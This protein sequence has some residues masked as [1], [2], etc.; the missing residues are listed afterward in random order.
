MFRA[1][2]A[3]IVGTAAVAMLLVAPAMACT[4]PNWVTPAGDPAADPPE[5]GSDFPIDAGGFEPGSV[6][7]RLDGLD[8]ES[9]GTA[10]AGED[11]RFSAVVQLPAELEPGSH[12]IV[13]TQTA[14]DGSRL[15]GFASISVAEPAGGTGPGVLVAFGA[16]LV[17]LLTGGVFVLRHLRGQRA[18]DLESMEIEIEEDELAELLDDEVPVLTP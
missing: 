4:T 16:A 5:P 10:Q 12:Q 7:L 8:G 15:W 17:L 3:V 14:A 1:R 11:G 13:A 6:D 2:L 18:R 9:L